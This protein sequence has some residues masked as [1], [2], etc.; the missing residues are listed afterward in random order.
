LKK[1]ANAK[2]QTI[3]C[4]FKDFE[5]A[6]DSVWID[7]LLY[8]LLYKYNISP[9]FVRLIDSMYSKL[10][11][12]VYSNG[13]LG[14]P[15]NIMIGTRQGCNLSPSLFNLFINDLPNII[16][17][18]SCDPVRLD[19]ININMLMYA[20]DTLILSKSKRGL[21][22][23]LQILEIYCQKW[24]L[25][26]NGDKTKIMVFNK[27]KT[28]DLSIQINGKSIDI[29]NMY[30]YLGL[31]ISSSGG[32]STAIKELSNKAIRA[33]FALKSSFININVNPRLFMRLF[34]TLV[35]PIALYGCEIWGAFGHKTSIL[36]NSILFQL[37]MKDNYPFEQLHLKSCKQILQ[38]S[39]KASN[40]G[41]RAEL[42][43]FPLIYNIFQ[44]ICKY[45]IRL[46][47]FKEGDLLY[48]ALTSQTNL[49]HN[50]W[51]TATYSQF[52][53]NLLK[54]LKAS[55]IPN[56]NSDIT[57][58]KTNHL[59]K[60]LKDKLKTKYL[61]IFQERI[62]QLRNCTDTKLSIYSKL[63]NV[64]KYEAYL[65]YSKCSKYITKFRLSD[66]YLPI[67]RGRYHRPKL[68]RDLRICPFCKSCICDEI[69]AFFECQHH[70]IKTIQSTYMKTIYD[71][72]HQI[73]YLSHSDK[74]LYF[75]KG[76]DFL[77]LPIVNEW[78]GK[79]N[80]MF[81]NAQFPNN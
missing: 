58:T 9:K 39:K 33:Y 79:I 57:K 16:E 46:K 71:I 54:E 50:S 78:F 45:R 66:H 47:L 65:N 20:D 1:Q 75:L 2:K 17:K 60:Q 81:K 64:Y 63:K 69:H 59:T 19:S 8:K 25:K 77:I 38:V 55:N 32:F 29:V 10:K 12:C 27:T 51:K 72:S 30:N 76:I 35:K 61:D 43:R 15:F 24:Q 23:A 67:E 13:E 26:I 6:F 42:G 74:L 56:L 73:E 41:V 52:T 40:F 3:Y 68:P 70:D 14:P 21:K 62:S 7:G 80:T 49:K 34:D 36:S 37:Y 48:H 22:K 11:S 5:K 18:G 4:C 31:K 44:S 53:S 28:A